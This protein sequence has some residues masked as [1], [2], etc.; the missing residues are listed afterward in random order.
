MRDGVRERVRE[1]Q[2]AGETMNDIYT[3]RERETTSEERQQSGVREKDDNKRE[4]E[5]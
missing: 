2:R 3:T 5:R 1:R 4:R